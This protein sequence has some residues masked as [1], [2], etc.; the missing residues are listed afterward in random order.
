MTKG[1]CCA[2]N[3]LVD[4]TY[5]IATWPRQGELTH[6]TEDTFF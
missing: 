2:G 1:I 5:P 4:I 6:I 3:M